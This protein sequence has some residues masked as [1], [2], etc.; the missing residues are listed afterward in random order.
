M[1]FQYLFSVPLIAKQQQ[2]HF[3]DET[4][5]QTTADHSD[6]ADVYIE[7]QQSKKPQPNH[8]H[9]LTRKTESNNK[10]AIFNLYSR[11]SRL[12]GE[13]MWFKTSFLGSADSQLLHKRRANSSVFALS[14]SS[15]LSP[16]HLGSSD[17]HHTTRQRWWLLQHRA[18]CL[19]V[20][21]LD[22]IQ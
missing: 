22:M 3:F 13:V 11:A 10:N 7:I 18:W 4:K 15:H 2:D 8:H 1:I 21:Y 19:T 17:M 16:C 12:W 6:W 9:F 14:F 20:N 5:L